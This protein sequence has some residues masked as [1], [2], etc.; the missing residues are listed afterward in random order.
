MVTS[1][2]RTV[3]E[4]AHRTC[5]PRLK[6]TASIST[7][8]QLLRCTVHRKLPSVGSREAI[9]MTVRRMIQDMRSQQKFHYQL[10]HVMQHPT[11]RCTRPL[12]DM[13]PYDRGVIQSTLT[14]YAT[15][16][17]HTT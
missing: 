1:S 10:F 5:E 7:S 17:P 3:V 16:L 6:G 2:Q 12:S 11:Q 14:T 4:N 13:Q 8:S 9:R 15:F